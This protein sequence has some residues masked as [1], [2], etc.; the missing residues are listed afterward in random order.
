M[1]VVETIKRQI[2]TMTASERSQLARWLGEREEVDW[3]EEV[4]RD[5]A[6]GRPD[7]LIRRAREEAGSGR[8]RELPT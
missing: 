8:A 5:H 6:A 4:R 1:G 7:N 3:E 2:E